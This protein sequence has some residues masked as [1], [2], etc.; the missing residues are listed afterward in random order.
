MTEIWD[1]LSGAIPG[2]A[3][4]FGK[5]L[6]DNS[7]SDLGISAAIAAGSFILLLSL[8][9]I[10]GRFLARTATR[11]GTF[12]P[13]FFSETFARSGSFF[14]AVIALDI[15]SRWL[16]LADRARGVLD[17]VLV[18][19]V[20]LQCARWLN[21]V[22]KLAVEHYRELHAQDDPNSARVPVRFVG[23]VVRSL[24]W[25]IAFSLVLQT[26][27]F[28]VTSLVAGLGISGIVVALAAQNIVS[29]LFASLMIVVDKP[30]V[31]GD[32]ISLDGMTG[33][34]ETIGIKTT[35][36]RSLDGELLLISNQDLL[37]SRLRNFMNIVERRSVF[38]IG[39]E[40]ATPPEQLERV[41]DMVRAIVESVPRA[42]FD[43]GHF[44]RFAES[45]LEFEF[46]V[47]IEGSEYV[48]F[49]NGIQAI[50]L[51]ICRAFAEEGIAFAFPTRTIEFARSA[52]DVPGRANSRG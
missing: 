22:V 43:R 38:K 45:S 10:V 21:H 19:A 5:I 48:D 12:V 33:R 37:K 2:E 3:S 49:M 42:R 23:I 40:Y 8:K 6:S 39:V 4:R 44:A 34:V 13:R 24:M 11:R 47:Y 32:V 36:L 14:F 9:R 28:D 52:R 51:G 27:G 17:R 25:I 35:R 41:P 26:I 20:I 50:N 31:V 30:F 1:I 29:D 15:G 7:L 16:D 46:S 18:I